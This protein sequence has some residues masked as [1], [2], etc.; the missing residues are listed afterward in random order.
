M[1]LF[2]NFWTL[3]VLFC[4]VYNVFL[5]SNFLDHFGTNF[6]R[7]VSKRSH[8]H[9]KKGWKYR[10]ILLY[11]IKLLYIRFFWSRCQTK[12]NSLHAT[13]FLFLVLFCKFVCVGCVGVLWSVL[14]GFGLWVYKVCG[15]VW[16]CVCFCVMYY[17]VWKTNGKKTNQ[18]ISLLW[19]IF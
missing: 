7:K 6:K 10:A 19:N 4:C 5:N 18:K 16:V 14:M 11:F 8:Y 15:G 3:N 2:C 1:N 9:S 13:L 17:V 12:I